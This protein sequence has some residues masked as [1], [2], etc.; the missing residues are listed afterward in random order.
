MNAINGTDLQGHKLTVS[1]ARARE[2]RPRNFA[3]SRRS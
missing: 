3:G 2:E 1:E